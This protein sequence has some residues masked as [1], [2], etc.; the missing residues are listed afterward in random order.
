[1]LR[2]FCLG[3]LAGFFLGSSKTGTMMRSRVDGFFSEL[4]GDA[5]SELK[6]A[7]GDELAEENESP[8][9]N[10]RKLSGIGAGRRQ[11]GRDGRAEHKADS[12][13]KAKSRN[14]RSQKDQSKHDAEPAEPEKKNH[15]T[16]PGEGTLP[17]D[18]AVE[19]AEKL[20]AKPTP[21]PDEDAP[22]I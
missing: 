14:S 19:L 22:A 13:E 15:G 2:S 21:P 5:Q 11:S 12:M 10:G 16:A 1:M 9:G 18:K 20:S 7:D 6:L 4:L 8:R 3:A 17:M